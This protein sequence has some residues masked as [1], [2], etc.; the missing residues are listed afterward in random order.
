MSWLRNI[1]DQL[2]AKPAFFN[3]DI[4]KLRVASFVVFFIQT[5]L[6]IYLSIYEDI[7]IYVCM[8][9]NIYIY[10]YIYIYISD[11]PLPAGYDTRLHSFPSPR[12][13]V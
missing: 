3:K 10:I 11:P 12:M 1:L 4:Y 8:C 5:E 2:I 7:F 9:L 13:I 6:S